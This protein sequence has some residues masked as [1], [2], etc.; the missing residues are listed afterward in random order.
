MVPRINQAV[1][2]RFSSEVVDMPDGSASANKRAPQDRRNMQVQRYVVELVMSS[3]MASLQK[4]EVIGDMFDY[5][6]D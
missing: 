6:H 4:A 1:H 3:R 5:I 2:G